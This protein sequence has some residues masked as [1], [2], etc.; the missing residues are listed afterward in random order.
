MEEGKVVPL[1]VIDHPLQYGP[2][3]FDE[4]FINLK[5]NRILP[6]LM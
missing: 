2:K 4:F 1:D 6:K 3:N 5:A